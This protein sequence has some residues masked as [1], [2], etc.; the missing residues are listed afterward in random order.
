MAEESLN[1]KCEVIDLRTLYPYDF[2]IIKKS[3]EKTGRVLV[4]HEAP[5]TSGF[6]AELISKI[7]EE[8]FLHLE[9]PIKRICG[10]DTPFPHSTEPLYFPDRFKVFEGIKETMNY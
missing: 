2:Q 1:I 6:G 10:Y 5:I 9:A 3:V 4:T 8:C 7:Q